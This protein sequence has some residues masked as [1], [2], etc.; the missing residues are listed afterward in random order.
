MLKTKSGYFFLSFALLIVAVITPV[1]LVT[2]LNDLS[3]KTSINLYKNRVESF[4][5]GENLVDSKFSDFLADNPGSDLYGVSELLSRVEIDDDEP[6]LEYK[7]FSQSSLTPTTSDPQLGRVEDGSLDTMRF[8]ERFRTIFNVDGLKRLVDLDNFLRE[9]RIGVEADDRLVR[10]V[11]RDR[12]RDGLEEGELEEGELELRNSNFLYTLPALG[13]GDATDL[14]CVP[15]D[16][17]SNILRF[18]RGE[19]FIDPL[20]H[21]CNYNK[22]EFGDTIAIPLFYIDDSGQVVNYDFASPMQISFRGPCS[23]LSEYCEDRLRMNLPRGENLKMAIVGS[24][25]EVYQGQSILELQPEAQLTLSNLFFSE[26]GLVVNGNLN[27]DQIIR[28]GLIKPMLILQSE[29]NN[30][31]ISYLE[32]QVRSAKPF[33]DNKVTMT[34]NVIN[35]GRTYNMDSRQFKPEINVD[36]GVVFG[37]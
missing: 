7:I 25:G 19:N 9:E 32:Y 20:E 21:P 15:F 8:R 29:N 10:A 27:I 12:V 22:L 33:S 2:S 4:N 14:E 26:L 5:I 11:E 18:D 31:D 35:S 16:L 30:L 28:D 24:R 1:V 17:N 13:T 34:A 3:V 36:L 37:N 23:D 6:S